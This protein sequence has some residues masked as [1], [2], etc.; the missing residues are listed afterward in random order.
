[1][2]QNRRLMAKNVLTTRWSLGMTLVAPMALFSGCQTS[3]SASNA[4]AVKPT[5]VSDTDDSL[6]VV[7][8]IETSVAF[9]IAGM[10]CEDCASQAAETLRTRIPAVRNAMVNFASKEARLR[11]TRRVTRAQVREAL[12]TLGFEARF[13]DEPTMQPSALSEAAIAALDIQ[14][15]THGDAIRIEDHL[16][17]GK[18]TIFDY[19]ADWCGPCHLLTPKLER[20]LVSFEN[21]ALR[22]VDI[23]SWKSAAA[24]Q[25]S[26]EFHL[27]GLPFTR[28]F[29]DQGNLLGQVQGNR[30]E[31]IEAI[32]RSHSISQ[33]EPKE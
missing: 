7:G 20:L 26:D 29:D 15:I 9:S 33:E 18:I 21:L 28:V 12:G 11:T 17:R 1:M 24:R 4:E 16:P 19:Y 13:A 32:I 27:P 8:P 3:D 30:I 25:A 2:L 10:S 23:V 31:E 5:P 14:T 22:K 6:T